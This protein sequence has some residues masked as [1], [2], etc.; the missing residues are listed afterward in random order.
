MCPVMAGAERTGLH[1]GQKSGEIALMKSTEA[2][3]PGV[4]DDF[5]ASF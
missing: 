1:P 3:V 5:A 4:V 2:R